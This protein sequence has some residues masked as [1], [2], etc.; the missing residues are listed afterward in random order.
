MRELNQE[1]GT[2][3]IVVTHDRMLA[4]RLDRQLW[5][6]DGRLGDLHG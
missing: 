1:L 5:M 4:K 6:Q 2:S 3:F